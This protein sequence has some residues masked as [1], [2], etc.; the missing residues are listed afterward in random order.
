MSTVKAR[1][2]LFSAPMVRALIDGRKTQTRRIL[3]PQPIDISGSS[4]DHYSREGFDAIA[5]HCK[6]GKPGDFLWARETTCIAPKRFADPDDSCVPDYDNDLRYVSYKADGHSEDAMRDY[7]LKWTPSIHV[8]RWASRLMLRIISVRVERL[9]DISHEDAIAEGI[10]VDECGHAI[11]PHDSIN[12]G[13]AASAFAEL[14]ESINGADS[15]KLN[16]WIWVIEFEVI[17]KNID[18]GF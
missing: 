13:G 8:P 6:H 9:N 3:K 2:I 18:E 5:R 7:K 16:P 14:W 1:P 11:R 17:Q 4:I 15:W 10:Q 12:W